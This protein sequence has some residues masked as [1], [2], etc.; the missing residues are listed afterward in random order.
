L[1]TCG[2]VNIPTSKDWMEYLEEIKYKIL[3]NNRILGENLN[4]LFAT[5]DQR[6]GKH[7]IKSIQPAGRSA[8]T[9]PNIAKLSRLHT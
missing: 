2:G 3:F 1:V 8:Q 7:F 5:N 6:T 4:T 9:M